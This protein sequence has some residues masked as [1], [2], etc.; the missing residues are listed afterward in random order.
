MKL[1]S[2]I[3]HILYIICIIS[4]VIAVTKGDLEWGILF[5]QY[6]TFLLIIITQFLTNKK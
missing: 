4:Q 1:V 3:I 2:L 6:A 5:L